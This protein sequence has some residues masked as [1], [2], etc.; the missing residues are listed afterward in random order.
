MSKNSSFKL[1]IKK[2]NFKFSAAHF[3]IFDQTH[4]ERLH[5]HNYHVTVEM[6]FDFNSDLSSQG[7]IVDFSQLKTYIK[8]QIDRWDEIVLLPKNHP[9]MK[10]NEI[11]QD[12]FESLEV[13]FRDRR[14]VFPRSEVCLLPIINTSVELLAKLLAEDFFAQFKPHKIK[15]LGVMVEET[16]GQGAWYYARTS[17]LE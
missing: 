17:D 7:F 11:F 2:E 4:A 15:E 8:Q 10:F 5:G 6:S 13:L 14:Y 12:G 9:D 1:Y 16:S 3:L